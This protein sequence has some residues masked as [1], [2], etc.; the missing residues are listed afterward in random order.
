MDLTSNSET[1][2]KSFGGPKQWFGSLSVVFQSNLLYSL[3][4]GLF[5]L[6]FIHKCRIDT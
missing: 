3:A 5:L 2:V 4:E 1:T 6:S